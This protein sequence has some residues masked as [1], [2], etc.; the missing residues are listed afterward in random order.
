M[1]FTGR[2]RFH[3]WILKLVTEA[4]RSRK[5]ERYDAGRAPLCCY[6]TNQ[7]TSSN[8]L[9]QRHCWVLCATQRFGCGGGKDLVSSSGVLIK[10]LIF[11]SLARLFMVLIYFMRSVNYVILNK[12]GVSMNNC[13]RRRSMCLVLYHL[14]GTLTPN[15]RHTSRIIYRLPTLYRLVFSFFVCFL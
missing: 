10:G 14:M 15:P 11:L 13:V 9:R 1:G 12:G 8:M 3:I 6:V 2:E 7:L 4:E 5:M